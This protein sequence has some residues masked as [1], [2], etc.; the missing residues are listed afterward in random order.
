MKRQALNILVPNNANSAD[1]K[2][3]P[4]I[5]G[6]RQVNMSKTFTKDR[7]PKPGE[8]C[9]VAPIGMLK[10]ASLLFDK[11]YIATHDTPQKEDN[12]V[13]EV[14]EEVTF[15]LEII[16]EGSSNR[17]WK[18]FESIYD[19]RLKHFDINDLENNQEFRNISI[20][21]AS[22]SIAEECIEHGIRATPIYPSEIAFSGDF[23]SGENMAYQAAINNLPL[24]TDDSLAWDEILEFRKDQE[25]IRK[26]REFRLWLSDGFKAK[27]LNQ[28]QYLIA[29][30]LEDYEWAI[31]KHGLKSTTGVIS[32][33][34]NLK[35]I[36]ALSAGTLVS[37]IFGGPIWSTITAGMLVGANICVWIA[38]RKI[39]REELSREE[40]AD[41][42]VLYEVKQLLQTKL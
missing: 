27:T 6:V 33:I 31:K 29:K 10:I 18:R 32:Q 37:G 30:R 2:N 23:P 12:P 28:A 1:A 7:P 16:R 9:A 26:F 22:K 20:A 40:F 42:A 5:C 39:E 4:L 36:S 25:A 38:E 35:S 8:L 19:D 11:V 34:L 15:G 24:V 21:C 17:I 14:P 3:A 41:V 13:Y